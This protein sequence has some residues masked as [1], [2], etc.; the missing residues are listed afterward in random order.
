MPF[1]SIAIYSNMAI[2]AIQKKHLKEIQHSQRLALQ[3]N[4]S[5]KTIVLHTTGQE[6]PTLGRYRIEQELGQGG[7]MGIVYLG[8]DPPKINRQ[9]ADK[10][11]SLRRY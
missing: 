4:S 5:E 1:Q 8:V 2:S 9:V 11:T 6:K 10:N 3:G 7:A